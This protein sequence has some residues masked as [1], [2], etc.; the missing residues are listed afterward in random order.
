ML[1]QSLIQAGFRHP[2]GTA[3]YFGIRF[4]LALLLP[5]LYLMANVMHT[6]SEPK[7]PLLFLLAAAGFYIV[8]YLLK[9][10]TQPT[11]GSY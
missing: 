11:P 7:S 5:V 10:I 1:R 8:P 6:E 4:L 3:I 9:L 2:K